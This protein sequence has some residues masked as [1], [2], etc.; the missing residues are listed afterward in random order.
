MDGL[1]AAVAQP[2]EELLRYHDAPTRVRAGVRARARVEELLLLGEYD[3]H[4]HAAERRGVEE[5]E[6]AQQVRVGHGPRRRQ[7]GGGAR[8]LDKG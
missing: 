1:A 2:V 8:H 5:D 7:R 4:E 6:G 3:A